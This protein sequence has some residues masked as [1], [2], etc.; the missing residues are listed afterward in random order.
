MARL[1]LFI[2]TT[3]NTFDKR[4][5]L[6]MTDKA[7]SAVLQAKESIFELSKYIGETND[8]TDVDLLEETENTLYAFY[9]NL[10]DSV[11]NV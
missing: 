10:H 1:D 2:F 7:I 5:A 9:Q 8:I 6:R 11:Y 3:M 4:T